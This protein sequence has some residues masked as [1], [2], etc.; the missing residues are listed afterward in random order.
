MILNKICLKVKDPR[1][2]R[3]KRY[4]IDAAINMCIAGLVANRNTLKGIWS[5]CKE[6]TTKQ[7]IRLKL[8]SGKIMCYSNFTLIVRRLNPVNIQNGINTYLSE[9]RRFEKH[10]NKITTHNNEDNTNKRINNLEHWHT[11]GKTIRGSA[12]RGNLARKMLSAYSKTDRIVVNHEIIQN[13]DEAKAMLNLIEG[14]SSLSNKLITGD[15]IFLNS[16]ICDVITKKNGH[17]LFTLKDNRKRLKRD[18]L[19][20]FKYAA[21]QEKLKQKSIIRR[22][23]EDA[24]LT[25]GRIEQR[26]IDVIDMPWKYENGYS[27]IKQICKI[28]RHRNIKGTE[29]RSTEIV[30]VVTSLNKDEASAKDLLALN[31]QHWSV[32]NNLHWIK[33]VVFKEDESKVSED[34]GPAVFSL[35]RGFAAFILSNFSKSITEMRRWFSMTRSRVIKLFPAI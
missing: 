12:S 21:S 2:Q 3:G 24:S 1:K 9:M 26:F 16:A 25:S 5:Y 22:Y 19:V 27:A 11:D 31:R 18:V 13:H 4:V 33:D 17:F 8:P 10:L 34:N 29:K 6:L 7:R 15:A 35:L 14:C 20:A 30:F 23:N 32:E 28:I